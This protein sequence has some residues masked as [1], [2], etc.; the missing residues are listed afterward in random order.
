MS[1]SEKMTSTLLYAADRRRSLS[2]SVVLKHSLKAMIYRSRS[3]LACHWARRCTRC[4]C[5]NA[6]YRPSWL[7]S[8]L[9]KPANC[10]AILTLMDRH[11][12]PNTLTCT[13]VLK[14][15]LVAVMT[16]YFTLYS[17]SASKSSGYR[18]TEK[19]QEVQLLQ[20]TVR[21]YKDRT[22]ISTIV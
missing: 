22:V 8:R 11:A 19:K 21:R 15:H 18:S 17:D 12:M 4:C 10:D 1:N 16:Y 2:L 5:Q 9:Y 20:D 14:I 7:T 13:N 3:D 6:T